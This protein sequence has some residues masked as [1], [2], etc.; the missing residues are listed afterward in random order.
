MNIPSN[1]VIVDDDPINNMICSTVI[2]KVYPDAAVVSFTEPEKG[3]DYFRNTLPTC[4]TIL[5]LDINMPT[6]TGWE[7]IDEFSGLE[8]NLKSKVSVFIVSSSVDFRD[9]E[10]ASCNS[11]IRRMIS[12]PLTAK[13]LLSVLE[14]AAV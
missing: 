13:M 4:H 5:F 14:N 8:S 10:R 3:L 2:K 9:R 7:F 1:F 12:K 6:M 11:A